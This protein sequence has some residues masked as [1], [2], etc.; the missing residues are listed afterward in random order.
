MSFIASKNYVLVTGTDY[1]PG[2]GTVPLEDCN[3]LSIHILQTLTAPV[4][5]VS[6]CGATTILP[7]TALQ[8]GA[9]YPYSV[10]TITLAG[11]DAGK[12]MGIS[13]S[14]KVGIF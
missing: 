7:V 8:Q 3:I 11:G 2:A 12:V 6:P 14:Y 10:K 5:I 1:T 9:I 13:P 4:T